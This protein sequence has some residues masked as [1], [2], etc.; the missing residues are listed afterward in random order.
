MSDFDLRLILAR[1]AYDGGDSEIVLLRIL[2]ETEDII[3]DDNAGLARENVL[4]THFPI[5]ESAFDSFESKLCVGPES[6]KR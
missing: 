5:V 1:L 6:L 2:E 3:A 4:D